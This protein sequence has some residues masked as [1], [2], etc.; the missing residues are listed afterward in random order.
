MT[1]A[2]VRANFPAGIGT[3]ANPQTVKALIGEGAKLNAGDITINADNKGNAVSGIDKGV[4]VSLLSVGTS[5]QPADSWYDTGVMIGDGAE[6]VATADREKLVAGRMT[7]RSA[8]QTD[9]ASTVSGTSI[10]IGLNLNAMI[11]QNIIHD[12]NNIDIG[13]GAKLQT[14]FKNGF[15]AGWLEIT[16]ETAADAK[17]HTDMT[18]GSLIEG[19]TVKASNDITRNARIN[20]GANAS[21][22]S[23][24][25]ISIALNTG[26]GDSISTL[27]KVETDG[28]LALGDA[29][30]TTTLNSNSELHVARGAEII[31]VGSVLLQA[32]GGSK[33]TENNPGI[34]NNAVV[35]ANGGGINPVAIAKTVLNVTNYI[36]I[37]RRNGSAGDRVTIRSA[38]GNLELWATN[39][40]THVRTRA[41]ADGKAAGGR[42]L[43][44]VVYD[45]NLQNTVWVDDANLEASKG[46]VLLEADNGLNSRAYIEARPY[47]E[48]YAAVG[49]VASDI[50]WSGTSFNQIRTNDKS[51]VKTLGQFIHKVYDPVFD[52]TRGINFG[53]SQDVGR[54][55]VSVTIN[56][57][58]V[59]GS[60]SSYSRC[61]FC[62]TGI[63]CDVNE[64]KRDAS[65]AVRNAFS[66]A[67][68]PLNDIQRM[69]NDVRS[70]TKARYGE[71]D[72]LA[73][74]KIYALELPV[75]LEKDVTLDN[76]QIL[77]YRLWTNAET[78]LDVFLLPN[79]TR[80][81]GNV[82]GDRIALNYVSEVIQG[83]VRG[84]GGSA[85]IDIITALTAYAVNHPVI[86]IGSAGSLDFS[87][88]TF[89][90]PSEA[91]FELYLHEVSGKWLL[92]K[93]GSGFIRMLAGDQ[94]EINEA[95]LNGEELPEGVIVEGLTE[96]GERDGWKLYWLGDT[97]ATAAD[98]EKT[99]IFLLVNEE[100]DEVD[101]FRTSASMIEAG[102]DP[103]DVSLYLYRDSNS[104]RMEVEKYNCM[105]FDTPE[106][107]KSLVKVVTDVL[108]GR[109]LEM[110]RSLKIVLRGFDI[111][112]T[113]WPVY[114]LTDHFFALCDGTDGKVSMFDGFYTNSFDGDT[115]DSDYI[116]I[117]GI[118]DGDLNVT[119][120]EGQP[121]WPEWT[122][123]NTA[124]DIAGNEYVRVDGEWYPAEE[125][126][127]AELPDDAVAA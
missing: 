61:D 13:K 9:A 60:L 85:L 94:D 5:E 83:D 112:G 54:L 70:I 73:A 40:N 7:I 109:E 92:D 37:N 34:D 64:K 30:A 51:A 14:A 82:L 65:S 106:G 117:E 47:G 53:T 93:L 22:L 99:L 57:S 36:D 2:H 125:A 95:V 11:G 87:T 59:I 23:A 114:S 6:L 69:V 79:S 38:N 20:I 63:K 113:D 116:R 41:N 52:R 18:G 84:D 24:S 16:N 21:I 27:A 126:P 110:P 48:L 120:K 122:G 98:A 66:K 33:G 12:E 80:L 19:T 108:M 28:G 50:E 35:K 86:P 29:E 3:Q 89:T 71:E 56:N 43:A 115:F 26:W 58:E 42:S 107:E 4:S 17:A 104:D 101:A 96:D 72:Y 25:S 68:S 74:G 55:S 102:E 15:G 88:G 77:K 81:Y 118:V 45:L 49:S 8:S 46:E 105:F 39:D 90:I 10:G 67:L 127:E 103:V 32:R 111:A 91:D 121:I 124:T 44:K 75:M 123:E 1:S 119:I 97:P 31:G 78:G 100:T 62:E 76:E